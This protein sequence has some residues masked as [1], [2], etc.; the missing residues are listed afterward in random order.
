MSALDKLN[1]TAKRV[2]RMLQELSNLNPTA[3]ISKMIDCAPFP[4]GFNGISTSTKSVNSHRREMS[5]ACHTEYDNADSDQDQGALS[6]SEMITNSRLED[7]KRAL[8]IEKNNNSSLALDNRRH[9]RSR[10]SELAYQLG[11]FG[12][13]KRLLGN[14]NDADMESNCSSLASSAMFDKLRWKSVHS[15]GYDNEYE[16]VSLDEQLGN[17]RQSEISNSYALPPPENSQQGP[18]GDHTDFKAMD[19]EDSDEN[20]NDEFDKDYQ[21]QVQ[22][23]SRD[24]CK[25]FN[26][27]MP[28]FDTNNSWVIVFT[29]I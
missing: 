28:S 6:D 18:V 11:S 23:I 1:V 10:L 12:R 8:Q 21:K 13:K 3:E 20:G 9:K 25:H 27:N 15:I 26:Y 22:Q 29:V 4:L 24:I 14:G 5:S 19:E 16:C 7:L 17:S 2:D